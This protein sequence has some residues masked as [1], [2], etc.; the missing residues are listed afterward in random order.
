[1]KKLRELCSFNIVRAI[2]LHVQQTNQL[3]TT[4]LFRHFLKL[5][6]VLALWQQNE[7]EDPPESWGD[8][9][10]RI[11]DARNSAC[12]PGAKRVLAVTSGGP[13]GQMVATAL[14]APEEMMITVNL[15]VKNASYS[16]FVFNERVFYLNGFNA[17]PHLDDAS[18][19]HLLTYS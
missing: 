2:L 14:K 9:K 3:L 5:K 17:T 8:F 16:R 15:Q 13:T 12:R 11:A 6:E 18:V 10:D 1:M 19:S 7:I 4:N